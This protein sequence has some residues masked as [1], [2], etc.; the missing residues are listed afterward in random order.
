[1]TFH[2]NCHILTF[3][4]NCLHWRQSAHANLFSRQNK[5]K[6]FTMSSAK[7]LHRV[8]SIE[9]CDEPGKAPMCVCEQRPCTV[10]SV[11][12]LFVAFRLQNPYIAKFLDLDRLL[13]HHGWFIP[14]GFI[15]SSA[16]T[17]HT[18]FKH[19]FHEPGNPMICFDGIPL[20]S[21]WIKYIIHLCTGTLK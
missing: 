2:A 3:H 20:C 19:F 6:Y 12:S 14:N 16:R 21:N 1:M 9:S 11:S 8:L 10:W 4:A 17:P 5:E 15:C 7:K 13:P 18:Y